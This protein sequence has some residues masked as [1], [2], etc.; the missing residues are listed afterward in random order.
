MSEKLAVA[1]A[2]HWPSWKISIWQSIFD[3]YSLNALKVHQ[4]IL[5]PV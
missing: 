2:V 4:M 3:P 5:K 1:A